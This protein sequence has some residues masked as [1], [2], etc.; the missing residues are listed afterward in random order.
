MVEIIKQ[1]YHENVIRVSGNTNVTIKGGTLYTNG[2]SE[3]NNSSAA[4]KEIAKKASDGVRK[5]KVGFLYT[6]T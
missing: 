2:Y 6:K 5:P 4:G 1:N 3:E